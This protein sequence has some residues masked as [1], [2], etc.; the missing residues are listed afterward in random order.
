MSFL[1][2]VGKHN[3]RNIAII[4]REIPGEP[5]MCLVVYPDIL[6]RH[7]HDPLMKCIESDIGQSSENLADALNRS[8][9][10]DGKIILQALHQEGQ[11]KKVNTEQVVVIPSPN[12]RI[13]LSELNTILNEMKMGEEAVKRLSEI[14]SSS[15]LQSPADVAKRMR[16][17]QSE[18]VVSS[19]TDVLGDVELARSLKQQAERMERDAKSLLAE[20]HRLLQEAAQLEGT[21]IKPEVDVGTKAKP[22]SKSKSKTRTTKVEV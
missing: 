13:K 16:N 15:G 17:A 20:S 14:D 6:N 9:T 4:F 8:Y 10:V 21:N 5:H 18:P 7:V 1:R 19:G 11:L 3:D 2:H 12:V 22:R